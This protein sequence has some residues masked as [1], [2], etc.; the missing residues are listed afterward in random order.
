[1]ELIFPITVGLT[2]ASLLIMTVFYI[3]MCFVVTKFK[4]TAERFV[5]HIPLRYYWVGV[6]CGVLFCGLMAFLVGAEDVTSGE[7]LAGSIFSICFSLVGCFICYAVLRER[8]IVDGEDII[9]RTS[10]TG[11]K[12]YKLSDIKRAKYKLGGIFFYDD[13]GKRL[14]SIAHWDRVKDKAFDLFLERLAKRGI[15]VEDFPDPSARK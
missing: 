13:T 10:F 1:M 3:R 7:V 11:T 15:R 12:H 8:T 4:A 5:L 9:C 2:A 14:F 6:V